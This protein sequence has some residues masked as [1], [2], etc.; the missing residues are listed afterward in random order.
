MNIVRLY[1]FEAYGLNKYRNFLKGKFLK[2]CTEDDVFEYCIDALDQYECEDSAIFI[3][4]FDGEMYV[5]LYDYEEEMYKVLQ[6]NEPEQDFFS[7]LD[8]ENRW[9]CYA[10]I[11]ESRPGLWRIVSE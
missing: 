1:C 9:C 8:G 4:S 11:V 2:N 7:I 10:L 6:S 3:H 5:I